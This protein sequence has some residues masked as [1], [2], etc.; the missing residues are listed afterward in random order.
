MVTTALPCNSSGGPDRRHQANTIPVVHP[1]AD[2]PE[3]ENDPYYGDIPGPAKRDWFRIGCLNVNNIS[4]Y[5]KGLGPRVYSTEGKDEGI[6]KTIM[7]LH[8]DVL[9]LQELGVNWSKVGAANQW[10]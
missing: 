2:L 1:V 8:L 9:L 4:P 6:C 5:G 7:D 10:K 3:I